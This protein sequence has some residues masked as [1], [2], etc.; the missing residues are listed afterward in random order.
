MSVARDPQGAFD[1]AIHF[2]F[3]LG[4]TVIALLVLAKTAHCATT[5]SIKHGNSLGAVI[6]FT[7]PNRDVEGQ[8]Q[9]VAYV[10]TGDHKGLVLRIQPRGTFSLFTEDLLFCGAP[11]DLFIGKTNPMVLTYE[12]IAHTMVEGIGCHV[13]KSVDEVKTQEKY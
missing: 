8:V 9:A 3:M 10:G 13:L 7:N 2:L 11:V 6:D 5:S 4:L 12:N 1:E